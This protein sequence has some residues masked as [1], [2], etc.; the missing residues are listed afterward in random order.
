MISRSQP[1]PGV[2]VIALILAIGMSAVA[3]FTGS[4]A[5]LTGDMG[6]CLPSPNMWDLLPLASWIINLALAVAISLALY[7]FNKNLSFS[8]G[9]SFLLMGAFILMTASN[10]WI[11]ERLTS[12]MLM[13]SANLWCLWIMFANFNERNATQGVFLTATI[14]SLG[15]MFQYAFVFMIPVYMIIGI[16]LKCFRIKELL[17]MLMGLAAPYWVGIGMGLIP[18]EAFHM[19]TF[20]NLFEGFATKTGLLAGLLNLGLTALLA[21]LLGLNNTVKL[22]AGNSRRRLMNSSLNLMG[23]SCAAMMVIDFNNLTAYM[24]TFYMMAA[25]Q[26]ANVFGLWNVKRWEIWLWIGAATYVGFFIGAV[27]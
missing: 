4:H 12:S 24:A 27:V 6:I 1:G 11:S 15:S 9:S 8:P 13:A 23:V 19:P 14:L 26:V 22:F 21:L 25:V 7:L 10:P 16:F 5:Q 18:L 20:T 3:F 2:Y 17:A